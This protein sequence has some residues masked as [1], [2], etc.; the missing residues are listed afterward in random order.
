MARD[1]EFIFDILEAAKLARNYVSGK[2]LEEFMSNPQCQDAVIRR[3]EVIGE[4]AGRISSGTQS[5]Y[6][7]I[8]WREMMRMRNVMI[9][10]YDN[11]D[12]KIVWDTVK[13]NL[14]KL[15]KSLEELSE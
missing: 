12:L 14:P 4:A 7:E 3:L 15:I 5:A 11:V 10:E 6:P 9:H 13:E 8:P 1:S 2:T